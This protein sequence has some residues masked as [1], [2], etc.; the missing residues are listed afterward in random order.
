MT[1]EAKARKRAYDKLWREKHR[2]EIKAYREKNKEKIQEQIK[3]YKETHKSEISEKNKIYKKKYDNEHREEIR[4]YNR[5]YN[6][7]LEQKAKELTTSMYMFPPE[8][9]VIDDKTVSFNN[10]IYKIGAKGYL[11]GNNSKLHIDIA[12]YIGIWFENCDI[13][14]ID[15]SVF[16][17]CKENLKALTKEEHK[18]V[19]KLLRMN[20]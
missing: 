10:K 11:K 6:K 13:H 20:K 15:G 18:R 3:H 1:E 19:H 7:K 5:E 8:V 16:N 9:V 4:K 17:N 12:K 2:E 14:H